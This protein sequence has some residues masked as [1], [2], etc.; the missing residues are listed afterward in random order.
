MIEVVSVLHCPRFNNVSSKQ[1]AGSQ[2][3]GS[4][5]YRGVATAVDSTSSLPPAIV[6]KRTPQL[7]SNAGLLRLISKRLIRPVCQSGGP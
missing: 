1:P 3:A 6:R 7:S 2:P 5:E 4:R